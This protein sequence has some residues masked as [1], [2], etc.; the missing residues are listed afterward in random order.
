[1]SS[2]DVVTPD[3][4]ADAPADAPSA[5]ADAIADA[6]ERRSR[7]DQQRQTR[8]RLLEAAAELFA[9]HGFGGA[10]LDAIAARAG[11]TRGA[12][13]SNFSDK[14]DLL[15]ALVE[16]QADEF[17]TQ[18][19]PGLLALP[20]EQRTLA[21]AAW[22]LREDR[23]ESLLVL[24]ELAR[25][26]HVEPAAAEALERMLA[27]IATAVEAAVAQ[28]LPRYGRAADHPGTL[29]DSLLIVLLGIRARR[30]IGDGS[31]VDVTAVAT[32]LDAVLRPDTPPTSPQVTA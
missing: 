1:M 26:R 21:V 12:V 3:T 10:S 27:T 8:E 29:V 19:L 2:D 20:P 18:Q 4:T 31:D 13:Y 17:R 28:D 25:V 15:V 14:H 30:I 11:Y 7:A 16:Q 6:P 22:L 9:E 5:T 24:L 32:L 23:P